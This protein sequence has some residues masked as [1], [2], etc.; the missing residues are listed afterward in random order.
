MARKPNSIN[1]KVRRE[2]HSFVIICR[3]IVFIIIK[4]SQCISE[5]FVSIKR[6]RNNLHIVSAFFDACA[7]ATPSSF[8]NCCIRFRDV[9]VTRR[10]FIVVPSRNGNIH[11]ATNDFTTFVSLGLLLRCGI[12]F[13]DLG[14]FSKQQGLH[15]LFARFVEF[16]CAVLAV[17]MKLNNAAVDSNGSV[18]GKLD[19]PIR[20]SHKTHDAG[21]LILEECAPS[22]HDNAVDFPSGT[23]P[24]A[25]RLNIDFLL[26]L[27]KVD[28]FTSHITRGKP[29]VAMFVV[30]VHFVHG[31]VCNHVDLSHLRGSI[32]ARV[33]H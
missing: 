6:R 32:W 3:I 27:I 23:R 7:N 1:V 12:N 16:G 14:H 26:G 4:I 9:H 15:H 2:S 17:M 30:L 10:W 8:S 31:L 19:L 28:P 11:V 5:R 22:S 33:L 29:E 21:K 24:G 18:L 25:L 13:V 20:S